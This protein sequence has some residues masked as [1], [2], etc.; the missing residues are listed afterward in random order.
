MASAFRLSIRPAKQPA[1]NK[2]SAKIGGVNGARV[3]TCTLVGANDRSELSKTFV[4]DWS[5]AAFHSAL[6]G[7]VA[8]MQSFTDAGVAAIE[9]SRLK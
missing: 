3:D 4:I 8:A 2:S 5:S 1:T 7:N 9:V 6:A